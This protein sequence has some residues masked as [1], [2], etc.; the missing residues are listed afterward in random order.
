MEES[1]YDSLNEAADAL[2]CL[3]INWQRVKKLGVIWKE[4]KTHPDENGNMIFKT[5]PN[6]AIEFH[7]TNE[8]DE[9]V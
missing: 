6:I 7:I 2:R 1:K 5:V 4:V 8:E 3:P 9:G